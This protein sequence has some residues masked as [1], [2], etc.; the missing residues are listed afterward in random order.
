MNE[1]SLNQILTYLEKLSAINFAFKSGKDQ[2]NQ[3]KRLTARKLRVYH[4]NMYLIVICQA[5]LS[6]NFWCLPTCV[7]KLRDFVKRQFLYFRARLFQNMIF[8]YNKCGLCHNY[9]SS[10]SSSSS[11]FSLSSIVILRPGMRV[12]ASDGRNCLIM[13]SI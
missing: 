10:S 3:N 11:Y 2:E 7:K 9:L 12:P 6:T 4:K 5:F 8:Q 1:I 13:H